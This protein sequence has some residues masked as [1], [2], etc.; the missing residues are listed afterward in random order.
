MTA[1]R[2]KICGITTPEDALASCAAGADALGLVFYPPSSRFVTMPQAAAIAAVVPPFVQRVG[3][4]VNPSSDEVEQ[5]L[6]SVELDLLQFHGSEAAAFCEQFSRPYIKALAMKPGLDIQAE[7]AAHPQA[8]GFLLDAYHPA[9]PGGTGEVFDWAHF[10]KLAPKPLIL[11]GGLRVENVAAAIEQCRPYAVDVSGGVE[12]APGRK[13]VE[14]VRA[15]IQ[16]AKS[17]EVEL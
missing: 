15:F 12:S 1:I 16:R 8:R 5:V 11:A 14:K 13:S 9:K 2:V 3:L 6:A 17:T 4:F 7:M 10:P